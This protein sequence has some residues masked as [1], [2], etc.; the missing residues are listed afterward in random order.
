MCSVL[1]IYSPNS[2]P[3]DNNFRTEGITFIG[4]KLLA[5]ARSSN[6]MKPNN[7]IQ[8]RDLDANLLS[9]AGLSM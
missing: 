9:L 4:Y 5:S 6:Q 1:K 2:C 3:N 7:E 8:S